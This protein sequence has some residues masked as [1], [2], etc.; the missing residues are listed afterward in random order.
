MPIEFN[1]MNIWYKKNILSKVGNVHLE[2]DNYIIGP[3]QDCESIRHEA[4]ELE[5]ALFFF[6]EASYRRDNV[7]FYPLFLR[8][9]NSPK[10]PYCSIG[11][12][13]ENGVARIMNGPGK[14]EEAVLKY[15]ASLKQVNKEAY[16]FLTG[17]LEK[18]GEQIRS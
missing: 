1:E 3:F 12:V 14:M 4:T 18:I 17:S 7:T 13:L 9:K 8:Y 6:I 11:I 5:H 2:D 15:N 16:S 10:V